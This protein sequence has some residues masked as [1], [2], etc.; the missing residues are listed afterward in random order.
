LSKVLTVRIDY[1]DVARYLA[2]LLRLSLVVFLVP[3]FSNSRIPARIKAC[4]ALIFTTMLFP[5]LGKEVAPLSFQPGSLLCMIA[6]EL[7]FGLLMALSVSLILGGF[8]L[9]GEFISYQAG[10]AMAQVVDP[11]GGFQMTVFSNLIEL[12]ALLLL[13]ALNGHHILLKLIVESFRT[14]PVGQ[15]ALNITTIDRLVLLSGQLFII[16]IK[17]AAPVGMV[18]FLIEIGL[19]VTS[20]FIPSL[21]ILIT[22][23][24]I[25]IAVGLF[26]IGLALPF[27]GEAMTHF[28]A[29]LFKYLQNMVLLQPPAR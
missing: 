14:I 18:L 12:M 4:F 5:L 23:F 21:N 15:F 3:P 24:P 28:F 1:L 6:G 25:A 26:F 8:E 22:S 16:G 7:I 10:L 29:E 11:Q 27:W 9:A 2:I 20:K 19:G 17:L 13:L